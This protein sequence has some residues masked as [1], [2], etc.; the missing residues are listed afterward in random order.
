MHNKKWDMKKKWKHLNRW[1]VRETYWTS[2]LPDETATAIIILFAKTGRV[3]CIVSLFNTYLFTAQFM[4]W[5]ID[6]ELHQ[7]QKSPHDLLILS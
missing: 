6:L 4:F 5:H 3:G 7:K 1:I 2:S